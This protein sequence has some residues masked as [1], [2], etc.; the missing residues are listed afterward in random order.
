MY[1]MVDWF[2]YNK[3]KINKYIKDDVVVLC[4]LKFATYIPIK[5]LVFIII[6]VKNGTRQF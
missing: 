2:E 4:A 5:T 1:K 6:I 3:Q